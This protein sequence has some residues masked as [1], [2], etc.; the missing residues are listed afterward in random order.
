MSKSKEPTREEMLGILEGRWPCPCKEYPKSEC[1]AKVENLC[2]AVYEGIHRL[3]KLHFE[4]GKPK[5]SYD[6]NEADLM[7]WL[8]EGPDLQEE[9]DK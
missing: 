6:L 7:D 5:V 3:I 9:G 8:A 1:P 2:I 4:Q